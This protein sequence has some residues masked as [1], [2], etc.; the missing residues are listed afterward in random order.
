VST[1]G[2]IYGIVVLA[3][4]PSYSA[5]LMEV[6]P[7]R[8]LG[9][10]FSIQMLFGWSATIVAPVVVGGILDFAKMISPGQTAPWGIAFGI[11]A[12]GPLVG[13]LALRPG[14]DSRDKDRGSAE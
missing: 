2:L 8:S 11:L 6:V 13:L 7:P 12:V 14:P 9:G 3:D 10:A 5:T 4:S 1:V